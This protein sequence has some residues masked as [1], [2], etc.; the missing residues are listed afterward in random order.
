MTRTLI[1][2]AADL[3]Q[4]RDAL[5]TQGIAWEETPAGVRVPEM[6]VEVLVEP[7]AIELAAQRAAEALDQAFASAEADANKLRAAI[8]REL[9]R[10]RGSVVMLGDATGRITTI[11]DVDV[12]L[13]LDSTT[14]HGRVPIE[15]L[16]WPKKVDLGPALHRVDFRRS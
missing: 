11:R 10:A 8:E 14:H 6:G 13:D 15:A 7:Q 5:H 12:A 16:S 4:L 2:R 1:M 3:D 9:D